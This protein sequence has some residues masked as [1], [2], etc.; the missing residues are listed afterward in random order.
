MAASFKQVKDHSTYFLFFFLQLI[1]SLCVVSVDGG[2]SV[3]VVGR[4]WGGG[5]IR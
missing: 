4:D 2:G 5:V 1:F 3:C